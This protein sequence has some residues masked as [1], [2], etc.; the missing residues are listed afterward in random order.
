MLS[1]KSS[2]WM[3]SELSSGLVEV[4]P[5]SKDG[6]E[7]FVFHVFYR[8]NSNLGTEQS[9]VPWE[10]NGVEYNGTVPLLNGWTVKVWADGVA[11]KCELRYNFWK[12]GTNLW[13][14]PAGYS[15]P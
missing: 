11:A 7:M 8:T 10:E 1:G 5:V 4:K 12:N 13:C 3:G 15:L 14:V 2:S 6:V 9:I